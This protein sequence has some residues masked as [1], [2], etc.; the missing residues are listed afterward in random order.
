MLK[1]VATL[2]KASSPT[3]SPYCFLL[4]VSKTGPKTMKSAPP[5]SAAFASSNEW[6]D[7]P[8]IRSG[9]NAFRTTSAL[10]DLVV[11]WTPAAA[12]TAMSARSLIRTP[13]PDL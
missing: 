13:A 3:G 5:H 10:N 6:V 4:A 2:R 8:M 12:H 7:T 1:P 11:R 9:P